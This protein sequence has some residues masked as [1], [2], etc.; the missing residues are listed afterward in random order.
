MC[1]R[2]SHNADL[3]GVGL[4]ALPVP[5]PREGQAVNHGVHLQDPGGGLPLQDRGAVHEQMVQQGPAPSGPNQRGWT[6]VSDELS[7]CWTTHTSP[8]VYIQRGGP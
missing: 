8:A 6:I 4:S 7:A 1:I 2:D 5:Q 3:R